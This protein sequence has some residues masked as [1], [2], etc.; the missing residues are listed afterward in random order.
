MCSVEKSC[1]CSCTTVGN[2][3]SGVAFAASLS[4]KLEH[5]TVCS[6]TKG[7]AG[8]V[9]GGLLF[10]APQNGRRSKRKACAHQCYWEQQ[11]GLDGT[12]GRGL[13]ATSRTESGSRRKEAKA[14]PSFCEG[15]FFSHQQ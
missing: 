1:K 12:R 5:M 6:K 13:T 7:V 15:S 10:T 2:R 14:E 3:L 9:T 4:Q 8:G 11:K